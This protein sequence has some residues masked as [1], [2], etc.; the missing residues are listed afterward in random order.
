MKELVQ[1]LS[2]L[3]KSPSGESVGTLRGN[4]AGFCDIFSC[5]ISELL[6]LY[7]QVRS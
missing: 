2:L 5:F 1:E 7:L 4:A 3:S 6:D